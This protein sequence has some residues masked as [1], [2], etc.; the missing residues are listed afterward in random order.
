MERQLGIRM[1]TSRLR[2][3]R[4]MTQLQLAQRA[5]L[6]KTTISNLESGRQ[7][8]IELTTIAKLCYAL[9]CT[10]EDLFEFV[11]GPKK[12]LVHSQ[13]TALSQYLGSLDYDTV[14]DPNRLDE[15][16]AHIVDSKKRG[17]KR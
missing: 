2:G 11:E 17:G 6:S 8:K 15:D 1:R 12:D 4:H 3:Q 14:F 16:L 9:E 5:H 7:T 10:P 13:K